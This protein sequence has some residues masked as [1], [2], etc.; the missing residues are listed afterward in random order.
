MAWNNFR[1]PYEKHFKG[2]TTYYSS[3]GD[4][5]ASIDIKV[6]FDSSAAENVPD[7]GDTA[8]GATWDTS[9][10]DDDPLSVDTDSFWA[11]GERAL[12]VW[13]GVKP[14]GNV[15]AVRTTAKLT[16]ATYAVYGWDVEFEEGA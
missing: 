11:T 4:V 13:N 15:G 12:S 8:V 6:R 14:I 2:I 9:R 3:N 10:W 7:I 1:T 5:H 16:N